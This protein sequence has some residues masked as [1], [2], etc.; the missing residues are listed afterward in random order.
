MIHTGTLYVR[1]TQLKTHSCQ[2]IKNHKFDNHKST[3]KRQIMSKTNETN[4][5]LGLHIQTNH[6]PNLFFIN[7]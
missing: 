6:K 4:E 7:Y 3:S 2:Q 5:T 1:E